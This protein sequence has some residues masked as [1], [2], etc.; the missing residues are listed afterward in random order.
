[1]HDQA[2]DQPEQHHLNKSGAYR[3]GTAPGPYRRERNDHRTAR[4]NRC[5]EPSPIATSRTIRWCSRWRA[6]GGSVAR[7]S[8]HS[9]RY[10]TRVRAAW[11][12]DDDI[13]ATAAEHP[14]PGNGQG[15]VLDLATTEGDGQADNVTALS[16]AGG[17][18]GS[19]RS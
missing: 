8:T 15:Q 17:T 7:P 16:S 3:D 9:E 13:V 5:D 14:A 12:S 11:V 2:G 19:G 18:N 1:M 10:P 4:R 6:T